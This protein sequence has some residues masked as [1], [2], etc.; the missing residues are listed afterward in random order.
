MPC[1]AVTTTSSSTTGSSTVTGNEANAEVLNGLV[2]PV[3]RPLV[4]SNVPSAL[5]Q[6]GARGRAPFLVAVL[7]PVATGAKQLNLPASDGT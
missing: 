1:R 3:A 5:G 4:L 6:H 2:G 7:D